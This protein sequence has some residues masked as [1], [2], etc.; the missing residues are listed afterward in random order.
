[1]SPSSVFLY[2]WCLGRA[3][4]CDCG[5]LWTFLLL[6]FDYTGKVI[7]FVLPLQVP[8][9]LFCLVLSLNIINL[10]LCFLLPLHAT[11]LFLRF[12]LSVYVTNLSFCFCCYY[13]PQ[14]SYHVMYVT[15]SLFCFASFY[16]FFCQYILQ[17]FHSVF[18]VITCNNTL[19]MLCVSQ[20]VHFCFVFLLHVTN[21]LLCFVLS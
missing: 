21:L 15:N 13:V 3:A 9:L 1:M 6:F 12:L 7:F 2:F 8:K 10:L 5:N 19:I 17:I 20:V 16:V 4:V 18:A 11:D 14:F